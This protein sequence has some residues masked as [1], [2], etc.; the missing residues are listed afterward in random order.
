MLRLR[1][2]RD[3]SGAAFVSERRAL[4]AC[5]GLPTDICGSYL[6][7]SRSLSAGEPL[8]SGLSRFEAFVTVRRGS[9]GPVQGAVA[10]RSGVINTMARRAGRR[11][12]C[13]GRP[14]KKTRHNG[15]AFSG[16]DE[17]ARERGYH[18]TPPR[19]LAAAYAS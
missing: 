19:R 12:R 17:P 6:R 1:M 16:L 11:C 2:G 5:R 14:I 18:G 4:A 7:V 10:A 13:K 15:R 8:F 9:F 3:L